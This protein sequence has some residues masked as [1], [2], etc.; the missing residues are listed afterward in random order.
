MR[1]FCQGAP[2]SAVSLPQPTLFER[3]APRSFTSQTIQSFPLT[4]AVVKLA[5]GHAGE[6]KRRKNGR[7]K[8][9]FD[10]PTLL[11]LEP[12][13]GEVALRA[14]QISKS[15]GPT[16][17][18]FEV[19]L[20]IV[21]GQVLA[22]MGENG[23]GKSTLMKIIAGIQTDF[24]GRLEIGE[25]E[26]RFRD[27]RQAQAAGVAIIHQELNLVPEMTVADNMFLGREALLGGLIIDRRKANA[28]CR[29]LL[30]RLEVRLDPETK[31]GS[32]R[33]GE[34]QLVEIAKALAIDARILIMDEPTS[35]LSP[36]ECRTLFKVIRQLADNGVAIV[37]ISHRIDEVMALADRVAILRDGRNVRTARIDELSRERIIAAMI[38]REIATHDRAIAYEGRPCLLSVRN[39]SLVVEGRQGERKAVD[40]VSFDVHAGEIF[41]IGGLLGS[42]RTEIMEWIFG[43]ARGARAGSI[44]VAEKEI[45]I[46]SPIEA[47]HAGLALLT[48]DR[49]AKGLVLHASIADN[50]VLP[51]LARLARL[52]VRRPA[53]EKRAAKRGIADV[54][55]R[56]R[57]PRQPAGALSGGNQQK[58]VLAKWLETGPRILLLD[59]PTRGID[60]GAKQEIYELLFKLA[61]QGLAIV[62]VSSELPE[63]IYLA[64]RILVMCEGRSMGVLSRTEA[65]EDAIMRLATPASSV[66]YATTSTRGTAA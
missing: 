30:D 45:S 35:A 4:Q 52:G 12:R 16:Q 37:Y 39:I 22:V 48:E 33:V 61:E 57:G 34:Q 58:V 42:G 11:S 65:S 23:A 19:D 14:R 21:A 31:I 56:C 9:S 49:K 24:S 66:A 5:D 20:D 51:S 8:S 32:L 1:A 60:V 53:E 29:R 15:F 18:L 13:Y 59:E 26:V 43:A 44:A 50:I 62:V 2:R 25:E 3:R 41:G 54:G 10:D 17:V 47:R 28:D 27:V 7:L 46:R 36:S 40:N 63:L 6:L 64:D 38:G 55:I